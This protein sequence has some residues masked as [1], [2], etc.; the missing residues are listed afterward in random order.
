[1]AESL[2]SVGDSAA[3][4]RWEMRGD[5]RYVLIVEKHAVFMAIIM[6]VS[7]SQWGAK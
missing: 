1:M 3:I 4:S 6:K 5:F 7:A 2:Q